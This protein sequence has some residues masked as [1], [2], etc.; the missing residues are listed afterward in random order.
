MCTDM[1]TAENI[2]SQAFVSKAWNC[3]L[4]L[5][6]YCQQASSSFTKDQNNYGL[7]KDQI[8]SLNTRTSLSNRILVF[9]QNV[10]GNGT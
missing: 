10:Y 1:I 2:I 5:V 4:K 3:H 8:R 7:I 9:E 6:R